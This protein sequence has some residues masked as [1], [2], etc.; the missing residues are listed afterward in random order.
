MHLSKAAALMGITPDGDTRAS[1]GMSFGVA[2]MIPS[3]M[4]C[5]EYDRATAK[6]R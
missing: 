6:P 3:S 1:T 2:D 5:K 4:I